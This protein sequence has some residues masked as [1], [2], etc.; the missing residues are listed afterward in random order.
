VHDFGGSAPNVLSWNDGGTFRP[1]DGSAGL[2]IAMQ[3]MGL[4]WG[5]ID[6]DG[7]V[8]L[9]MA[10]WSR[11][12]IM[13]GAREGSWFNATS[14]LR[15][16]AHRTSGQ[17][18]GWSS[19]MGDLDNDGDLD[20]AQGYG[21][22]YNQNVT[23]QQPD[24]LYIQQDDGVFRRK[25][26][27]WGFAHEGQTRGVLTVDM[28]GDGWLDLIRRDLIG[29]ATLQLARCGEASW[30]IVRLQDE[31]PNTTAV[32]AQVHFTAGERS[33]S[34]MISAGGQ[35]VLSSGP[36]EAHVG[37]DDVEII[38]QIEVVW[39]DGTRTQHPQLPT[40]RVITLTRQRS[41]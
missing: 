38:D 27:A 29:P 19:M 37:L 7:T 34:R 8:D 17:S 4:S 6:G 35:S 22:V 2:N 20:I 15:F 5:D 25:G 39:P 18:I 14:S 10:G 32:G 30:S 26:A 33:W 3:G 11:N 36:E 9:A 12:V 28:N 16:E 21:H 1:D 31:P 24:D 40:R 23:S 13:L 41:L